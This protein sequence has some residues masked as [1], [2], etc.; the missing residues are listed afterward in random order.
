MK[1]GKEKEV[2]IFKALASES[3]YQVGLKFGFD[4]VY[5]NSR[6]VRNAVTTIYTKVKNNPEEYGISTEVLGLVEGGMKTRALSHVLNQKP[7]SE[8]GNQ[9]LEIKE[10]IVGI[11]DKTFH[12]ID[13]KLDRVGSSKKRL[14]AVSFKDLGIIAGIAFD[15]TQILRG[16]ATENVA[17]LGKIETDLSPQ[18][19]LD[20]VLK[21]REKTVEVKHDK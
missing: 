11:R 7:M 10:R 21:M 19:A 6:A 8:T 20:L 17:V 16:E 13:K 15:K 4:K 3:Q 5:K 14:D 2:E 18:A 12:L 1:F 9:S